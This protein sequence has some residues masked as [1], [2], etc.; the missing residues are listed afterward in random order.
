MHNN[1]VTYR[2][3][4]GLSLGCAIHLAEH[5]TVPSRADLISNS[6][7]IHIVP[8]TLVQWD[9]VRRLLG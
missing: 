1:N 5:N 2:Y 6:V 4:K 7:K 8:I 9:L 3:I